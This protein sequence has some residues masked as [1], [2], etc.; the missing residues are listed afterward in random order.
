MKNYIH[1]L[2]TVL[3]ALSFA[4][5][6]A[7]EDGFPKIEG[8]DLETETGVRKILMHTNPKMEPSFYLYDGEQSFGVFVDPS[9]LTKVLVLVAPDGAL[10]DMV[11]K[12]DG[13]IKNPRRRVNGY[14]A[15]LRDSKSGVPT[16]ETVKGH[17]GTY[18][19]VP[20]DGT[21]DFEIRTQNRAGV[22]LL[23]TSRSREGK[24][25]GSMKK[26]DSFP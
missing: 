25:T 16:G 14:T 5:C 9:E 3:S 1:I 19:L 24:W 21:V 4:F 11:Y 17:L 13:K 23:T 20:R 8:K 10:L 12:E 7:T 26:I 6:N 22:W 18:I 2:V 15:I